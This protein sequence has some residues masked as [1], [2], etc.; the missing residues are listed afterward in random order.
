MAE[1]EDKKQ[2]KAQIEDF[3]KQFKQA[4]DTLTEFNL[5]AWNSLVDFAT[6]YNSDSIRFTF[7]NGQEIK[8]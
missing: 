7:K 8:A 5:D 4:P 2:Q 1:L 3:I 6:V